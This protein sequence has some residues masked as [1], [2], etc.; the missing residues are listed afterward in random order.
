[1]VEFTP[2]EVLAWIKKLGP[3]R[4]MVLEGLPTPV[5]MM[6]MMMTMMMMVVTLRQLPATSRGKGVTDG[7]IDRQTNTD[8]NIQHFFFLFLL[9]ECIFALYFLFETLG[10]I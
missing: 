9:L 2:V 10:C 4:S 1:M 5:I 3:R 7:P 6:M 8:T